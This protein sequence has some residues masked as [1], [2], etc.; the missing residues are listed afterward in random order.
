[1]NAI[2][3]LAGALIVMLE[4]LGALKAT[5]RFLP[6]GGSSIVQLAIV[7]GLAFVAHEVSSVLI[8]GR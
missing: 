8:Y 6:L 4:V 1:M 7:L 2:F 5:T 3:P